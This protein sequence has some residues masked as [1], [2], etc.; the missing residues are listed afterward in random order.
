MLSL[1]EGRLTT[2]V[3]GIIQASESRL[4]AKI[5]LCD[6]NNESWVKS[7]KSDFKS[8]LQDLKMVAKEIHVLFV[9]DVKKVREEV[10]FKIQELC[11][12]MEKEISVVRTEFESINKKV[13]II[14]EAVAKFSK[15]YESLSPQITQLSTTDNKNFMEVFK[16]LKE[17]KSLSSKPALSI[18]SS[19]DLIQKFS[20]FEELL[21]QKLAPL[22][23]ISS[24]SHP[25]TKDGGNVWG[26]RTSCTVS[27]QRV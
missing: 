8:N 3:S 12:D 18:L 15:L 2:K 24:L 23:R 16:L 22:S 27:Q 6:K 11:E 4:M 14:C 7:Q 21:V 17:L 1:L 19:E 25:Q 5:D 9:Q 26:W 13:D 10:N 20:K